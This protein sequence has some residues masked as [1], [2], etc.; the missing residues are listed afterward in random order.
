[1]QRSRQLAA[2]MFTD[3][4]GYTALM[5]HNEEQAILSRDK[6]RRIFNA[7]TE[8]YRGKILQYY[9]DGTLSIFDSAIDAV[10]CGI[11]MQLGFQEEPT[12]PVRIGIHTGDIIFSEEEI[13]GDSVNVASRIESLAVPGSIFISDKVYDEIKNQK[14]IQTTRLKT[15]KL[16]N[17]ERPIV[18][19]AISNTGLVIPDI[20]NIK[21]KTEPEPTAVAGTTA[22]NIEKQNGGV[23]TNIL[24]T[25]LYIPPP[26]PKIVL[27]PRLIERLNAGLYGKLILISAPAGF[28]KTTLVSGW[29]GDLARK[30]AWLSLD[31]ADS[32]P[33]RFMTYLVATLQKIEPAIGEGVLEMLQSPQPPAIE[34]TLT[35]L[36][37]DIAAHAPEFALILDDYHLIDAKPVDQALTFLLTHLPPQMKLVITTREDPPL[38]L[39]RLRVRGQ[40]TELRAAD[41][42][43]TNSE[44]AD[45][46]NQMMG[47]KLSAQDIA[48]LELRTE[49][50]IAGLQLAAISMQGQRDTSR[51][52]RSF[53]GSHRFVLDYLA[54]EVLHQQ[55]ENVQ[56]FLLFTS[57]LDRLCASLC[58][59]VVAEP[60]VSGQE[61]LE[62]LEQANLFLVPLDDQ[63]SWYRYQHLFGDVLYARLLEMNPDRIHSLHLRASE[64]YEQNKFP[65][66]AIRHA[67]LAKDFERAAG[68]IELEW[69]GMD[70]RFQLAAWIKWAKELPA[71][72][73]S[74]RPVLALGYAWA[75]LGLGQLEA[76][77]A[78][79]KKAEQAMLLLDNGSEELED[80]STEI[81]VV[82]KELVEYLPA[83]IATARAYIALAVGDEAATVRH[84]G[85]ALDLLPKGN[86]LRR[87]PAASLLGLAHWARGELE[88]AHQALAEAMT[89]FRLSGNLAFAISGT[90]GLADIRIDQGRLQD[91]IHIYK[92][93]LHLAMDQGEP[94]LRGT[95]DL[96][97][98]LG[99]LYRE[100]GDLE[101]A[102]N[103]LLKSEELGEQASLPD[104]PFRF[105]RARARMKAVEEE[106]EEALTL[107]DEAEQLYFRTPVPEVRPLAAMKARIWIKQGR[108]SEAM[109]W[110][111]QRDLSIDDDLHYLL[112]FEHVTLVRILL[113]RYLRENAEHLIHDA[114]HLLQ[115]LLQ[116]AEEHKRMGSVIEILL[117][118]ALALQAY[119]K[120][121]Q[122]LQPLERALQLAEPE[123][124]ARIFIDEGKPM[125]QLLYAA[126]TRGICPDYTGKLLDLAK[127]DR[128]KKADQ[129]VKP[130]PALVEP[131]S[132]RELEVLQLIAEG[133]SNQEICNRLFLALSTIKGHNR[134]IFDKLGVQRRTEAVA[135]ARELGLL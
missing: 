102:E 78:H 66:D 3:I 128:P 70:Q 105:R 5:Q 64:W 95:A 107:L 80:A 23:P 33:G 2:I 24:A 85:K 1:M 25:K 27:R 122:A 83:S 16:K 134:K 54:E 106:W 92:R 65:A 130:T 51:F 8:K 86:R 55:T 124:Y 76:G 12:I 57:I 42:R 36:V 109:S 56:S 132:Q 100:Q 32:D 75:E 93:A 72:L 123:G 31:E 129:P 44:A 11:E 116:A 127:V 114:I 28:G 118:Q 45:F 22:D 46:L 38:P 89:N 50:W 97:L 87:G 101:K 63:R 68:L 119:G 88:A 10:Q 4:Q 59:A 133:Y 9:G 77:E 15:F 61:T 35:S 73:I 103:Y 14:S 69:S 126:A 43:F 60:A 17:V 111:K 120:E 113:A 13:I 26:R 52:I 91:A 79:L 48:A 110:Q 19:Y 67:L 96:Y 121:A 49:G 53:T 94:L 135:R 34:S 37:N 131:L 82:D 39:A 115:R 21:G 7:T 47:L 18:V 71:E 84:A 112:E 20:K 58:D 62:Y 99:E 98:G 125:T 117:L 81:V 6:H 74:K 40:L 104:S 30:V 41:L 90:Y 29:I 108:I